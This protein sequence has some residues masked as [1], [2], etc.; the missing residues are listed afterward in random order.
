[1]APSALDPRAPN[2]SGS[3]RLAESF[4]Q[5]RDFG[6]R[7]TLRAPALPFSLDDTHAENGPGLI[8]PAICLTCI[9]KIDMTESLLGVVWELR[10]AL[11][12]RGI[13]NLATSDESTR[14]IGKISPVFSTTDTKEAVK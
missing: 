10:L 2:G 5:G 13:N 4:E 6:I 7:I 3:D 11:P 8:Q 9:N 1:M 12:I 14:G